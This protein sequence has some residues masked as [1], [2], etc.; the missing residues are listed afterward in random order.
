MFRISL[1]IFSL[2]FGLVANATT[3]KA[4]VYA[5]FKSPVIRTDVT[6]IQITD[7]VHVEVRQAIESDFEKKL[8]AL[9]YPVES[10]F[11]DAA[12]IQNFLVENTKL[13]LEQVIWRGSKKAKVELLA[14]AV[15]TTT[16]I[17]QVEKSLREYLSGQFELV[18][19]KAVSQNNHKIK[20][21][22]RFEIKNLANIKVK[23]RVAVWV[24]LFNQTKTIG[25]IPFWF[26]V[27]VHNKVLVAEEA[28]NKHQTLSSEQFS[29]QLVDVTEGPE[30]YLTVLQ[31]LD[32]LWATRR[33]SQGT[34]I[35]KKL[36]AKEP[37]IKRNQEV[38]IEY[39]VKN[40]SIEARGKAIN[41]GFL[42]DSIMILMDAAKSPVK[43]KI[44][45]EN[46]VKVVV[47]N[48]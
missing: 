11:L 39:Q 8:Q 10:S 16:I 43:A 40:I 23:K 20:Q 12:S 17:A 35:V 38:V 24:T 45:A 19:L 9:K 25:E 47:L 2:L 13:K 3:P 41:S 14:K 1:I 26:Q 37:L 15:K 42:G 36:V 44:I 5:S 29:L 4:V 27:K 30:N 28:I 18:E 32:K 21:A 22:T 34:A 33:I 31:P 46:K 7:F 6:N 48:A